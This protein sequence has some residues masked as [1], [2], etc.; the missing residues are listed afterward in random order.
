MYLTM[1]SRAVVKFVFIDNVF[2]DSLSA[3]AETISKCISDNLNRCE[4][5]ILKLMS[6]VSNGAKVMT[7]QRTGVAAR[8]KQLNSKL[9]N[10]HCVCHRLAL[11]WA[12]ASDG[13]KYIA[14]VEEVLLQLWKFLGKSP[15]RTAV[16]IK[17]QELW[18]KMRLS[19]KASSVVTKKV[20]KACRT[21]WLST[22]NAV[23]GVHEDF[24]PIIQAIIL[25]DNKIG[26]VSYQQH[27]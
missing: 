7:G 11:A 19:E 18:R 20:R 2:E 4:I 27:Y 10:V 26:L 3:N 12:G 6:L 8:L 23:D 1:E 14:Q 9:I 13:T 16:Q 21:R 17:A 5:D 22:S 24:V 15:K 25:T